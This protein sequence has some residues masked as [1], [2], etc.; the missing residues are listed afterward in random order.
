MYMYWCLGG[1]L[2]CM[3]VS[4]DIHGQDVD[5]S[6]QE[7]VCAHIVRLLLLEHVG[8]ASCGCVFAAFTLLNCMQSQSVVG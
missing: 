4:G 8:E 7:F 5:Y 2:V 6:A 1:C 3:V